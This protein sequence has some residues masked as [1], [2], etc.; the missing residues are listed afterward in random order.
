MHAVS[1]NIFCLTITLVLALCI[2]HAATAGSAFPE[3][4]D[5]EYWDLLSARSL[6]EGQREVEAAQRII[7]KADSVLEY[8]CFY[9]DVGWLGQYGGVFSENRLSSAVEPPEFDG[10]PNPI[11]AT[12]LDNALDRVVYE[13]LVE[14]MYSFRH[15]Y[16][17]GYFPYAAPTS[18]TCNP[19]NVVWHVS[20][21]ELLNPLTWVE[22]SSLPSRDIRFYPW[23]CP[24]ST[25]RE[26]RLEDALE[27]AFPDADIPAD[28]ISMDI[29]DWYEDDTVGNCGTSLLV[30][31]GVSFQLGTSGPTYDDHVCVKPKCAYDGAGSCS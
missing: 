17:G 9:R 28:S 7:R 23:P 6:L 27:T 4:C 2:S 8:S 14:F 18:G 11:S 21:C 3:T 26:T 29:L 10:T 31:T 22:L 15:V 25:P 19:M 24:D 13:P 1:K 20:K 12:H 30:E 5:E 16:G